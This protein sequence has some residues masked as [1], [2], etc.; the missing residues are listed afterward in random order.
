MIVMTVAP[1]T[2][3]AQVGET[4]SYSL[5]AEGIETYQWQYSKDGGNSWYRSSAAGADTDTVSF[6]VTA[7]NRSMIYRCKLTTHDEATV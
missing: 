5:K 3:T 4:A 1:K 7:T 2:C 6:K